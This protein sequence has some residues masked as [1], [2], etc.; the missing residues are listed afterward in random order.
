MRTLRFRV[1]GPLEMAR[2]GEPVR[3]GGSRQRSLLALLLIAANE[4]VTMEQLTEQ[5][6][7]NDASD[8]SVNAVHVAISRLRRVLECDDHHLLLTRP[9][10]YV[11]EV[12]PEQLDAALFQRLL[13]EGRELLADGDPVGAATRLREALALWRGPPLVDVSSLDGVQAEIR[14]LEELR[15]VA[16]MERI[17]AELALGHDAELIPELEALVAAHPLR[18]RPRAQLMLA[19]YRSGRQAESLAV[20]RDASR[21]LRE[22]LGLEPGP[23]LRDLERMVLRQD[24]GLTT[25]AAGAFATGPPATTPP[26]D[27]VAPAR[28]GEP[29]TAGAVCPFKGLASFDS[30]DAEYFC[31]R[32]RVVSDLVAR[33]AEWTLVGILGPSGIGKSSLLRAGVLPALR[34]GALPGSAGWRQVLIRPGEHPVA[35]LRRAAGSGGL[36]AALDRLAPGERM[37]IAVDQMEE[38]FTVCEDPREQ[39]AF[40]TA[41]ASAARDHERRVFV[42]CALRADFYG[43]IGAHQPFAQLLSQSHALVGPMGRQE[44]T[45]AVRQP[46]AR[47]GLVIEPALVDALVSDV[48]D[49]PGGL[50][51]LS[52][53]LLELWLARQGRALRLHS[54]RSSGGVRGAVARLAEAA[55]MRLSEA[56]RPI[57]ASVLLRLV[58]DQD[59]AIIRR[60]VPAAELER[61]DG[62]RPVVAALTD[63][64][65]LTASE[66]AIE[67]SHEALL[68]EWPRYRGWLDEDREGRRLHAHLTAAAGEWDSRGR[69]PG[70]L[71]RGARLAGALDWTA[72]HRGA[73]DQ[74]EREFIDSSRLQSDR[75]ARRQRSQNRR[76]RAL[77]WGAALLLSISVL[78]GIVAL[79]AQRRATNDAH[80]AA[81]EA[82]AA[83]GRQLGAEAV[84]EPRLDVAML[85][86]REAVSLDRSPQTEG[87]LLSTLLRYPAVVGTFALPTDSAPQLALSPDGR[88]LAVSDGEAGAV[89]FYDTASHLTALPAL[90]DFSGDE[91]PAYSGDGSLLVY[92]AGA[93]LKVRSARTLALVAKL[94]LDPRF[95]PELTGQPPSSSIL[96]SPDRRMVY[97]AYW[98]LDAAGHPAGAYVDRWS[99][100]SGRSLAPVR[101]D[102]GPLLALRL[103]DGGRRLVVVT[104]RTVNTYA[105]PSMA[106]LRSV[107]ITPAPRS[108]TAAAV[109]P[110][111]RIAAIGTQ[112]GA[113]SF[114][115]TA[116][117]VARRGAGGQGAAVAALVYAAGGGT[118]VSI[119]DD[120]RL[121]VWN[122]ATA[123]PVAA[124][125]GPL[126]QVQ[127]AALSANGATLYT[128]SLD[129]VVL[130][131]DLTGDRSFGHRFHLS[132]A[133]P[134]CDPISPHAPP[135]ALSANGGRIAVS[136][137]ASTIGVFSARTL[138]PQAVFTV[139]PR[140]DAITALAWS[141][142]GN[143][144]AVGGRSGIVQLW[145]L[146]GAP[147]LVR[148]LSGLRSQTGLPDAI[149]SIAFSPDGSLVAASADSETL[150]VHQTAA[151]PLATL[152]IWLAASGTPISVPVELGLGN[153]PGGS[154]VLAFS[155]DGKLLA[156]SLLHGGVD[157]LD[158]GT[159]T[160]RRELSDPGDDII[161]LAFA[162]DGTLAT[163]T[164]AGTVVLF[165]PA[166]GQRVAPPLLV[167]SAPVA[168]VAF[169]PSGQRFATS[170]DQDGTVKLWSTATLQQEG[171]DFS[172]D[173][174]TTSSVVFS[175]GGGGLVAADGAGDVFTWPTAV[176]AWERRACAVA[177]RNLS[178]TEWRRFVPEL[179]YATVCR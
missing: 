137:G 45:Q 43:R 30:T 48:I 32:E 91:P 37:V 167:A 44:L 121:V 176:T 160:V 103:V 6:F 56:E 178:R 147:R 16:T 9:G 15:L 156:V 135:V 164:L 87:A 2:D 10:G 86:A 25:A 159:G 79:V 67:L 139:R 125:N 70:D 84:S 124:W 13:A 173:P 95:S 108:P 50:P 148:S 115:D 132:P 155:P 112:S 93:V 100:P 101:I 104:A 140:R 175:P 143:E 18:E 134:C 133:L 75:E 120:N 65:L 3:L 62:A 89:R 126:G 21:M 58:R 54:Y 46:A 127:N 114:V 61:I 39:S 154:D 85:L 63:A 99:L 8:G 171:P 130:T 64:R 172:S 116:T 166:T 24:A 78:A 5:L 151:L 105:A 162:R 22:E 144:L 59:G 142:N 47:A 26:P 42:I 40:L 92:P 107:P 83:L 74:L 174:N 81:A 122:P 68:R 163:G 19:L 110:D 179:P 157:V 146:S 11:L 31:G 20:Y 138:A 106:P 113:V 131:W 17:E 149:Q 102:A 88:T 168:S 36:D 71:Y 136:L 29:A 72:Q 98:V 177:S 169:D 34:A 14:R 96:I 27:A 129:G 55:Y 128:A 69:D 60:R 76:L 12:D 153:G 4:M 51:L 150:A 90:S 161:S 109:S 141:P 82:R 23:A 119:G 66:G 123:T 57:A 41:L 73:L 33:L 80:L 35:E 145:D 118:A 94:S 152:G 165:N 117:G 28:A 1:L 7:G 170:G 97:F 52:T 38:L 111:G 158:A 49:E 53:S 77:L